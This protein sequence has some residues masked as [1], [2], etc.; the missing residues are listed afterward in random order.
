MTLRLHRAHLLILTA[1]VMVTAEAASGSTARTVS[2]RT[3]QAPIVGTWAWWG[4]AKVIVQSGAGGSFVGTVLDA[5]SPA[6]CSFK[7]KETVW[8]FTQQGAGYT[9]TVV[10]W[11]SSKSSCVRITNQATLTI[12]GSRATLVTQEGSTTS[13]STIKRV[14]AA[15]TGS[16]A[17]QTQGAAGQ[18]ESTFAFPA[19]QYPSTLAGGGQYTTVSS[20][21]DRAKQNHYPNSTRFKGEAYLG[22]AGATI[23]YVIPAL[24]TKPRKFTLWIVVDDDGLHASGE[25]AVTIGTSKP[26]W[27]AH[28]RNQPATATHGWS[29]V[30]VGTIT[31]AGNFTIAFRKD[32]ST[33]AAFVMNAFV[34][35]TS[36]KAPIIR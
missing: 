11:N 26:R 36:T 7:P 34:L 24:S 33:S 6:R 10:E 16:A 21:F 8:K 31:T 15:T 30:K 29:V 1:V 35:T 32:A 2:P 23:S 19:G 5:S 20:T 25:R 18:P 13:T 4:A 17:T 28:W 9:G 14:D 3:S 27:V 22:D 12:N